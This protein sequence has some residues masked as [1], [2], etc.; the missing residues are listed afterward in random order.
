MRKLIVLGLIAGLAMP[1]LT[2]MPAGAKVPGPNGR[3]AFARFSP[4]R[5]W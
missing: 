1:A 4:A 2:A 5:A 3:I